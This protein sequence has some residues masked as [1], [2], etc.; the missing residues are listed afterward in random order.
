MTRTLEEL[1][2]FQMAVRDGKTWAS[3]GAEVSASDL[4][5]IDPASMGMRMKSALGIYCS[6]ENDLRQTAVLAV[7]EADYM[8]LKQRI[9]EFLREFVRNSRNSKPET[10]ACLILDWMKL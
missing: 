10:L 7:S 8:M 1:A 9:V 6:S 5:N 2:N 4:P 3:Q